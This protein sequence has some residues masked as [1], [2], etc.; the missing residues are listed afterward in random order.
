MGH[1]TVW[2]NNETLSLISMFSLVMR[3]ACIKSLW[4]T[5]NFLTWV[6]RT[7]MFIFNLHYSH[8][9]YYYYYYFTIV[10]VIYIS[11]HVVCACAHVCVCVETE[12][13]I[14]FFSLDTLY[15]IF[16][17]TVL[18]IWNLLIWLDWPEAGS[19]VCLSPPTHCPSTEVTG[20]TAV[21]CLSHG[22]WSS[23]SNLFA[24]QAL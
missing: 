22:F 4:G 5:T 12:V 8:C 2:K 17:D 13:D 7:H 3:E 6:L 14:C 9:Y 18:R 15:I 24:Q 21:S 10:C 20:C 23:G 11:I 19:R 16:W 1:K